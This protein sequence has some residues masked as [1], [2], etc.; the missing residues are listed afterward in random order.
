MRVPFAFWL[1][2]DWKLALPSGLLLWYH[3]VMAKSTLKDTTK[4]K[5]M[6]RPVTTGK[7]EQINVRL[8]PD[9]LGALDKHVAA[10]GAES[11]AAAI[12]E[13]LAG[14]FKRKGLL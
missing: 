13:V 5:K 8:L 4:S 14:Y 7:G 1:G 11:R 2:P 10:T 6:G 3:Y 12:R 9:L